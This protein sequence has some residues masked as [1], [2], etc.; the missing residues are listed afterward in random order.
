METGTKPCPPPRLPDNPFL[1]HQPLALGYIVLEPCCVPSHPR[2]FAGQRSSLNG[3][4]ATPVSSGVCT[5]QGLTKWALGR[6]R[7][8]GTPTSGR[9]KQ[10]PENSGSRQQAATTPAHAHASW[11]LSPRREAGEH[12][13]HQSC[14]A[15]PVPP[16]F[17]A[18]RGC[19]LAPLW[20][21]NPLQD[22]LGLSCQ[23]P[24]MPE[25]SPPSS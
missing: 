10:V 13:G 22:H 9:R 20:T 8:G 5:Q 23:P 24:S 21:Y 15:S 25:A 11:W 12:H 1:W 14:L 6:P 19:L 16:H 17:P 4:R 7:L 18:W 3:S 2:P